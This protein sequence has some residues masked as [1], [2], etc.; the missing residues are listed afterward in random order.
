[1]LL[2]IFLISGLKED[3]WILVSVCA[4]NLLWYVILV[5]IYEENLASPSFVVG[6]EESISI[7]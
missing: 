7:G 5:E 2:H 3:S 4:F 1:M 6:K